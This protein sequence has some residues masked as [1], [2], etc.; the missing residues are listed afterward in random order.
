MATDTTAILTM[1]LGG[2]DSLNDVEAYLVD[3][4]HGRPT[5]P[6]LV[7]EFRERYRR[8]GRR[9]PLLDISSRQATGL[10]AKL[11]SE[12]Y[13]VRAYVGMRHWHPYIREAL[14]EIARGGFRRVVAI[15]LTPYYSN[16]SVGAYVGAVREA[17]KDQGLSLDVDHIE[18]WNDQPALADAFAEKVAAGLAA[19]EKE[20]ILSPYVLFTAHSLPKKVVEEGDPYE[21]EVRKTMESI[22]ARLPPLRSRLAYQS[23]GR[24]TDA[25]LGPPFEDVIEE[26]GKKGEEAILIVPFGFVSD[27]LEI[28]Y[29]VDVEAKE[30]A[31]K[32]GVRLERT[33]SLN[34]DPKLI[35]AL[36]GAVRPRL[37]P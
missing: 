9:S 33:Q 5:P 32:F 8:I 27:N 2:P 28:L 23:A 31:E 4:R 26:L 24:T 11:I 6:E 22:K 16:V 20:G 19:F 13:R 36:A 29:D 1:A 10:E 15:S 34:A 37:I 35:E 30:R 7:E 3:V 25:W 17:V 14:A 12:G 21:K 18:S